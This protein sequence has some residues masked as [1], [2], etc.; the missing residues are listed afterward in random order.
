MNQKIKTLL[1]FFGIFILAFIAV[2]AVREYTSFFQDSRYSV[3]NSQNGTYDLLR[4][5]SVRLSD[6][7]L[8]S[9]LDKEYSTVT[10][11]VIKSVVSIDTIGRATKRTYIPGY[12]PN[13]ENYSVQGMGS[14]VIVSRQ[15]HIV[16]NN[17]VVENKQSIQ[18]TLYDGRTFPARKIGADKVMDIAVLKIDVGE[19]LTPLAFGNSDSVKVGQIVFAIGNP[20]GLSETVTQGIISAKQRSFGDMQTELLQTDAAINPGNSGGPLVNIRGEIIGI[21][22]A[23]YSKEKEDARFQGVSFSIPSNRV[24]NSFE[25]ICEFGKPI[26]GYIGVTLMDITPQIREYTGLNRNYGVAIDSLQENSPAFLAGLRA[27]DIILSFGGQTVDSA[28]DLLELIHMYNIGKPV[29]I[30][31]WRDGKDGKCRLTVAE[32]GMALPAAAEEPEALRALARLGLRV[33]DMPFREQLSAATLANLRG[34]K[35]SQVAEGSVAAKQFLPGDIIHSID[36]RPVSN[37]EELVEAMGNSRIITVLIVRGR[38]TSSYRIV[39]PDT[40]QPDS[41]PVPEEPALPTLPETL[42]L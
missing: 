30:T 2:F 9:K 41:S 8:L 27:G 14:G 3:G 31:Y 16:T 25:E 12:G 26:R 10:E 38:I 21:N 39:L 13:T 32:A 29:D 22:A 20:F 11:S 4:K 6:I 15:G 1:Y 19:H 28:R 17:H 40:S 36:G 5:S 18:V 37:K 7:P 23:I 42:S 34:V 35:I 33:Q 24:K